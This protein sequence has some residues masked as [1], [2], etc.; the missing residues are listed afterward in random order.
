MTNFGTNRSKKPLHF[1]GA[2]SVPGSERQY[3][4][5]VNLQPGETQTVEYHF[6][7]GA[8]LAGSTVRLALREVADGPRVHNL[9]L[10]VP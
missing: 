4:P 1:R 8:G 6:S 7:N 2:A 10:T 5:F 3:R 9:E